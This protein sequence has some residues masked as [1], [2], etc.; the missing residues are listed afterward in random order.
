[1][2]SFWYVECLARAGRLDEAQLAFQKMLTYANHLG[3]YSE[4]IGPSTRAW[5]HDIR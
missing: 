5:A 4:Q 1:M 2:C 3:L